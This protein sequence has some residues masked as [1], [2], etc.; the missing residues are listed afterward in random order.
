LLVDRAPQIDH[1]AIKFHV[2]IV[3]VPAPMAEAAHA[4]NALPA[5][6][7]GEHRPEAVPSHPHSL[8]AEIYPA[9]E[10]QVLDIA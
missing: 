10:Q 1:L 5:D 4:T 7:A 3:E 2:H 8:V 6:V 9:F